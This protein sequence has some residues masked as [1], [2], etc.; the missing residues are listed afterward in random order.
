MREHEWVALELFYERFDHIATA[1]Q[2]RWRVPD[3]A[4]SLPTGDRQPGADL[5]EA[6]AAVVVFRVVD[7]VGASVTLHSI[8]LL[9]PV[10]D[11]GHQLRQ[12][13][14]GVGVM[15]DAERRDTAIVLPHPADRAF[16]LVS[17]PLPRRDARITAT[18]YP[19]H[20]VAG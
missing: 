13:Q 5:V 18:V 14:R 4:F 7:P 17:L 3:G 2:R 10:R 19:R 11:S 6:L 15:P 20:R 8:V 1:H 9:A 12:M 16:R